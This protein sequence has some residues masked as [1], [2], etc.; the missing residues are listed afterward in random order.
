MLGLKGRF[1]FDFCKIFVPMAK[2]KENS[3]FWWAENRLEIRKRG[4]GGKFA[5][6]GGFSAT[7]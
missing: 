1:V 2:R 4:F 5:S 6:F 3:E 7:C